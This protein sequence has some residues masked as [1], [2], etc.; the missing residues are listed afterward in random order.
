VVNLPLVVAR[1][2]IKYLGNIYGAKTGMEHGV[3][4]SPTVVPHS[5]VIWDQPNRS[6]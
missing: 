3:K 5:V 4:T 6:I 2:A 1:T